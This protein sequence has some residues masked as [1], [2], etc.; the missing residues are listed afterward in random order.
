MVCR[1]VLCYETNADAFAIVSK[2]QVGRRQ[3][4]AERIS[5]SINRYLLAK[6]DLISSAIQNCIQNDLPVVKR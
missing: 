3:L 6:V 2:L 4:D 1:K 5:I